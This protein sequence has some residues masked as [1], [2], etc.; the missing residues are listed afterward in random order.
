MGLAGGESLSSEQVGALS[1]VAQCLAQTNS[2]SSLIVA[3]GLW[4]ICPSLG[5]LMKGC[6]P[7]LPYL[8]PAHSSEK[9]GLR[10]DLRVA[11]RSELEGLR[12]DPA[13][14]WA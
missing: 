6:P 3:V 2:E 4:G 12:E 5:L 8:W 14:L 10:K 11:P 13:D 1:E 7:E 9:N